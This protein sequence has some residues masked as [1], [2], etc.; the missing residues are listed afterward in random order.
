MILTGV[1]TTP[2]FYRLTSFR[3]RKK[4]NY[5]NARKSDMFLNG[6]SMLDHDLFLEKITL[7]N[8]IQVVELKN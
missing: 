1:H 3:D 5:D 7:F 2:I 4:N 8:F 6:L